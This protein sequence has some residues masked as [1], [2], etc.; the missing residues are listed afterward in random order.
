MT[1]QHPA[2]RKFYKKG[3]D[4]VKASRRRGCAMPAPSRPA[5]IS[6]KRDLG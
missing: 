2:N 3:W 4:F 6:A 5:A 1:M